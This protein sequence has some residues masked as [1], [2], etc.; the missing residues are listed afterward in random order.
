MPHVHAIFLPDSGVPRSISVSQLA[1][2]ELR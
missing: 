2:R 1:G